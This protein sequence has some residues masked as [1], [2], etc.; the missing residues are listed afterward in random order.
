MIK[1]HKYDKNGKCCKYEFKS[2]TACLLFLRKHFYESQ[3]CWI[4]YGKE[5]ENV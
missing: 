3:W 1:L 2:L 5:H 4:F